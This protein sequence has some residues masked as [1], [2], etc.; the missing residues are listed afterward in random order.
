LILSFFF[1]PHPGNAT[2]RLRR[3]RDLSIAA[4]LALVLYSSSAQSQFAYDTLLYNKMQWRE[5]G[6]FRGGR[7]VAVVGHK[8]QPD[9]AGLAGQPSTFYSGA[10]GGRITIDSHNSP[11]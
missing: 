10:T 6:P 5:I 9:K 3:V 2:M 8:D 7:S 11:A 4:L 1:Q